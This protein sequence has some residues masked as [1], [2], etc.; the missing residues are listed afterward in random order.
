MNPKIIKLK[1]ERA[2]NDEKIATLRSRN[3]ELDE[4]IVELENTD[5]IGLARATGMSMEELAQ[6]LTQLKRGGAPFI[7]PN[8]KEDTDYVHEE[9]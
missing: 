5:I 9:E 2:K 1:A 6:F 3:R 8:T 4:S 7:T